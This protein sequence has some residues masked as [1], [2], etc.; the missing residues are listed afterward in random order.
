M[1]AVFHYLK[2]KKLFSCPF[3]LGD[4]EE[5]EEH[6]P[7]RPFSL[8]ARPPRPAPLTPPPPA[9]WG[10]GGGGGGGREEEATWISPE[11]QLVPAS[12]GHGCPLPGSLLGNNVDNSVLF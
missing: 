5:K 11:A 6:C 12:W 8:A 4:V 9:Y 3:L 10:G 2:I 7:L 1:S